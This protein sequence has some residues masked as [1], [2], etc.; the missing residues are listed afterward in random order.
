[1]TP[2]QSPSKADT[3]MVQGHSIPQRRHS[4]AKVKPCVPTQD[5]LRERLREMADAKLK[6]KPCDYISSNAKEVIESKTERPEDGN[7]IDPDLHKSFGRIPRYLVKRQQKWA[8]EEEERRKNAPDPHCPRG[9]KIMDD[10]ERIETLRVLRQSQTE[11]RRQLY[12]LP[13]TID[14]PTQLRRKNKLEAKLKEIEEA[15]LIFDRER[16]F[17]AAGNNS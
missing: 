11:A 15:I 6:K 17:I 7:L 16:V 2:E 1:M 5:E 3:L 12:A 14:T 9:M 10:E 4:H 8:K 13:L